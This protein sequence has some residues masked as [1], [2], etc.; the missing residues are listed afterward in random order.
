MVSENNNS[1][2]E[3]ILAE[4]RSL[5][6][7]VSKIEAELGEVK[8]LRADVSKL[9]SE[10]T[11]SAKKMELYKQLIVPDTIHEAG[12]TW[13]EIEDFFISEDQHQ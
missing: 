3:Q 10:L 6:S 12:G 5:R 9:N 7:H 11:I 2:L 8:A 13:E 4:V 1:S